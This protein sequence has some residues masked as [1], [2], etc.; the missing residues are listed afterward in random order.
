MNGHRVTAAALTFL[1]KAYSGAASARNALYNCNVLRTHQSSLPIISVGNLTAGGSAKTP[2]CI[3]L[4]Q[5][6]SARGCKP[7]VLSRGYGG[8]FRGPHL[9][10][11]Q[12]A[13]LQVGDEAVLMSRV[14]G[15]TVVVAR[16]RVCGCRLIEDQK[17][18]DLVIL[19]DGLQHRAL[20]RNVEIVSINVGTAEAVEQFI[21]GKL[22]P[23]GRFRE[24]RDA[25]LRRADVVIL[26]ERQPESEGRA[27][28]QRLLG[29]IP[30]DVSVFRSFIEPQGVF[31]LDGSRSLAGGEIAAFCGIA[32]PEGFFASLRLSGFKVRAEKIFRDHHAFAVEEIRDFSDKYPGIPLVCS[33]KDAVKIRGHEL[34]H[35]YEFRVAL[36]VRRQDDLIGL[37]LS[38]LRV[39]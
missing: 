36:R 26:A 22:L 9:V 29:L 28:D 11:C 10:S 6:L 37:L 24:D 39:P 1:S 2:L 32:N 21:A 12:D 16:K 25:G 33:Q 23:L 20:R 31:S 4:A 30:Q 19:D 13:P 35:V 27:L 17:L 34:P 5:N 3:F 14:F 8:R 38:K 7:V 15:L 18:G